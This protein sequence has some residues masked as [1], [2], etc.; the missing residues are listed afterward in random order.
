MAGDRDL[1]TGDLLRADV[2]ALQMLGDALQAACDEHYPPTWDHDRGEVTWDFDLGV[3]EW[4][5]PPPYTEKAIWRAWAMAERARAE[6]AEAIAAAERALRVAVAGEGE[7]FERTQVSVRALLAGRDSAE[8][9]S[10][11]V[12][13]AVAKLRALGVTP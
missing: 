8:G 11:A 5:D 3:G 13:A 9:L 1:A 7:V 6:K 2:V 4:V 12:D 10:G